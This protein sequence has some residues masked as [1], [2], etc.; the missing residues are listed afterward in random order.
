MEIN[1]YE[2]RGRRHMVE[3]MCFRCKTTVIRPLEECMKEIKDCYQGL[4]DLNPPK[5]WQNG[6]FYYPTFCPECAK[7]YELFMK[8]GE[9]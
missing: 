9:N 2:S 7:A 6:R 5:G 3:F 4:H 8:G 1:C